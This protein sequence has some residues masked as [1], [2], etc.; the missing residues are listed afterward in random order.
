MSNVMDKPG[1]PRTGPK[2]AKRVKGFQTGDMVRAVVPMGKKVGIYNRRVAIR[3]TGYFD[4]TTK[5][6][7]VQGISYRFCTPIHRIDGYSYGKGETAFPPH[8]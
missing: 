3:S 7:T 6:E 2:Q 8:G 4:I 5:K 1:F